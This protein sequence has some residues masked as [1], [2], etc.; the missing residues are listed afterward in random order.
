MHTYIC[1]C[2]KTHDALYWYVC[3]YVFLHFDNYLLT[4]PGRYGCMRTA[5]CID[6]LKLNL[7]H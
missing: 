5:R 4:L 6:I 1:V 3:L 2:V 7:T